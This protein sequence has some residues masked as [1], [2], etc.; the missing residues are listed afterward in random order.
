MDQFF[1]ENI[2]PFADTRRSPW[3]WRAANGHPMG[4]SD[5][6]LHQFENIARIRSTFFPTGGAQPQIGFS[7]KP[8]YMDTGS[9]MFVLDINGQTVSYRHG[10]AR[11][12]NLQWPS[13]NDTTNQS[14]ATFVDTN[15]QSFT[16]A[17]DGLWGWFKLL[18]SSDIQR[19]G[20]ADRFIITFSLQG[21]Q[22]ELELRASS[23]NNP[24]LMQELEAFRCPKL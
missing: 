12:S 7:L 4:I 1:N 19:S 16:K 21:H 22:V 8:V 6:V 23:V 17:E 18:Q 13:K 11:V 20:Q 3:R 15:G 2:K 5:R 9:Q 10:P 14:S 24:F